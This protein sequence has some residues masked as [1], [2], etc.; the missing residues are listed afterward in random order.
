MVD[1]GEDISKILKWE[2]LKWFWFGFHN[3]CLAYPGR[4]SGFIRKGHSFL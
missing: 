2:V 4:L 1:L 3:E